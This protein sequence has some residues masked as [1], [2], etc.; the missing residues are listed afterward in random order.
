MY[1]KELSSHVA[2]LKSKN[3]LN[4]V[5]SAVGADGAHVVTP[6]AGSDG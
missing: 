6:W 1:N 4:L 2:Y 5:E 3:I